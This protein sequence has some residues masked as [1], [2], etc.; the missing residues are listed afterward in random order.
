MSGMPQNP[1]VTPREEGVPR[2]L[3]TAAAWSWRILVVLAFAVVLLIVVARLHVL[4][5]ALFVALL[6]TALLE[7]AVAGL[8]RRGVSNAL[9]TVLVLVGALVGVG[10]IFYLIGRAVLG[11]IDEFQAAITDG[12]EQVRAWVDTTFGLSLEDLAARWESVLGSLGT[13]GGGLTASAFGFAS[14]ALEVVA[15]AGIALFAT[16]FFV[17]DGAGMWSWAASMFPSGARRRVDQA[18]RLSWQTLAAYARGTVIIA[19]IDAVGIGLGVALVGV[20]LAGPIAVLVFFGAFIPIVGAFVSGSVAV[21]IALATEGLTAALIVLAVV[22]GVQ[23]VEGH[24]LQPLIQ[25]RM[26]ALHPLVV[27]LAVAGGSTVAGLIGAVIAVPVVAVVNVLVRYIAR[28]S[29]GELDDHPGP[30]DLEGRD[31]TLAVDSGGAGGASGVGGPA[32]DPA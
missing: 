9:S 3:R 11:Q 15:G 32:A 4:F 10:L 13:Q 18:A 14:T 31:G 5:A 21:I 2:G 29:R 6:A 23:Q 30:G 22:V 16:I 20:P 19:A 8:R 27:V 25:G 17:H 7:P 12:F 28:A 24:I 26:V 1:D